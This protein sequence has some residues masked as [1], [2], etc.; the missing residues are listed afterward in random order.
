M[1]PTGKPKKKRRTDIP[2]SKLE[3]EDSSHYDD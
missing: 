2:E 3:Q 1:T